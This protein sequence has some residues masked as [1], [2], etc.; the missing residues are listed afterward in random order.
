MDPPESEVKRTTKW[1]KEELLPG[2]ACI[3]A[4]VSLNSLKLIYN[5]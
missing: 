3:I 1:R 2:D 5:A 4:I